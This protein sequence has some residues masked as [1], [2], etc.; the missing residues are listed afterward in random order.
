MNYSFPHFQVLHLQRPHRI[1]HAVA[2]LE[3][4]GEKAAT[5]F[6]VIGRGIAI[7]NGEPQSTRFLFQRL[8]IATQR[9]QQVSQCHSCKL[10]QIARRFS[11]GRIESYKKVHVLQV[12]TYYLIYGYARRKKKHT[13][14]KSV[15]IC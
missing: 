2:T 4:A 15:S 5:F 9:M 12:F 7:A 1:V 13:R 14:K 10:F 11:P 8:S 3:A 6:Q